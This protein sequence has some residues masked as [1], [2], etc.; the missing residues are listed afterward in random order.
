MQAGEIAL[1]ATLPTVI[2]VRGARHNNLRNVDV[3]VPLWRIVAVV[4]G[5]GSAKTSVERWVRCTPK[6]QVVAPAPVNPCDLPR[7]SRVLHSCRGRVNGDLLVDSPPGG[8]ITLV[9]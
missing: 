8:D 1:P 7:A 5:S 4:G 2:S 3:D 9:W 6:G